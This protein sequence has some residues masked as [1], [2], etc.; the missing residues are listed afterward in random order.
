MSLG[1]SRPTNAGL[2]HQIINL[3]CLTQKNQSRRPILPLEDLVDQRVGL[4]KRTISR[5][6][7]GTFVNMA[8]LEPLF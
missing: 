5:A 1:M 6:F 7:P 2:G 4:P 8:G 3:S